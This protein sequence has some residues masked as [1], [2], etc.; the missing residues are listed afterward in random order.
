MGRI[1]FGL[2]VGAATITALAGCSAP[3]DDEDGASDDAVVAAARSHVTRA[4]GGAFVLTTPLAAR[5]ADCTGA[6]VDADEDGLSDAWEDLVLARL[7]PAVTFDEDEPMLS[8][9][10]AT[11]TIAALG[12]VTPGEAGRV[13]V[14]VVLLYTRDY[15]APTF[16]CMSKSKHAGDVERVALDVE[17]RGRG[18]AVVRAAFTTGHEGTED[19]QSR[20]FSGAALATLESIDDDATHEPRWRV[21]GSQ[22]K[23]AT[24]ATKDLCEHAKMSSFTHQVCILENCA[25]DRVA[26]RDLPRYTRLPAVANAGEPDAPR[27]DD[28]S[29]LGFPGERAWGDARFCGGLDVDAKTRAAC[30][31]PVKE[32]LVSNPFASR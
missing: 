28:L 5:I 32:K 29:A 20:L 7:R 22:A 6:C 18:D 23:H 25:P 10:H 21:Y 31:P 9:D 17:I 4:P 12:R 11:D 2:A 27:T 1:T 30:P 16:F 14:D 13:F 26:E 15:G 19:D 8:R 3:A 24:Y